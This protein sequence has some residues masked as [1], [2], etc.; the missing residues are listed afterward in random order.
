MTEQVIHFS[1]HTVVIPAG[2][3]VTLAFPR[4]WE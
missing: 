3:T 1:C 4:G 2:R